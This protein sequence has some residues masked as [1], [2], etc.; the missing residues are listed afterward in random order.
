[1]PTSV[2]GATTVPTTAVPPASVLGVT[3]ERVIVVDA[4][5]IEFTG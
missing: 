3:T 1:M 2:L 5:P 4:A